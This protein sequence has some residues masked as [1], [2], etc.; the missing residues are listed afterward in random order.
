MTAT[1]SPFLA[2]LAL[3][4]LAAPALAQTPKATDPAIERASH[5]RMVKLLRDIAERSVVD[6]KYHG[7]KQAQDLFDELAKL[8]GKAPWKLRLDA[9]LA[10][11]RLGATR[12]GIRI[13]EQAHEALGSG[14]IEGDLD[15]KN[16][17]RFYLGMAW[18]RLAESDN[19][20]ARPT[21]ESCILPLQGGALHVAKEGSTN[22]IP[23][24]REV[25]ENTPA[26]DF[27]HLGARWL[28]NLAHMTLGT[29]PAG[30]EPKYLIPPEALASKIDFPRFPNVAQKVGLEQFGMLGGVIVDDFDG[31]DDL[32]IVRSLWS[33]DGQIRFWRNDGDGT[34]TDRTA[35]S[36]LT[37]IT[38]GINIFQVDHDNDGDLDIFVVRGA[39]LYD[40]GRHPN[41]LL[42]NLGNGTF[43]DVTFAAGLGEVHYPSS[44]CDWADIDNDGDLDLY[45]GNETSP[46]IRA[47]NQLFRNDGDGTFY[48]IAERAGV[49]NLGYTKGVS[50]GDYD[51]D[52]KVD[53]YV[54]NL[55][56]ENRL[57]HNLGGNRFE[58]V[59]AKANVREPIESFGTWFWDHDNDGNL[60]L[61]VAA[62]STGVGD[63]GAWYLGQPRPNPDVMR[64]Y[65]GDG[66]GGFTNVAPQLGLDYPALP[67]GANFGDLDND[68]W[69]D[70]YLGT[71][72][73][74]YYNLMPN[75]MW[76]NQEGKRFVDIST[77]GGFGHLQKGHGISFADLDS[78]GDLDVYSVQGGAYPGDAAHS[79]LFENPGFGNHW[80]GV[81]L[82]GTDSNR[83]AVGAR[84]RAVFEDGGKERT[85]WREV[86]SG[87]SFGANPLRQML[88]L[89]KATRVKTLEITWPRS[90]KKQTLQDLAVDR[91]V[92]IVEGTDGCTEV[93]L[94]RVVLGGK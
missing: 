46:K 13:L 20:C 22:A 32:D 76:K 88:G 7:R 80:L 52:G 36:G 21:P 51:G 41:S 45:V 89:G 62:Y 58:D 53:L 3:L 55:H 71:G 68:G 49:E 74:Y 12:D 10:H 69:L 4:A 78:D 15:A 44:T 33:A 82:V 54:S 16:A 56:N 75:L 91:L 43:V 28:L 73:P 66:R 35:E 6:H 24:F 23:F 86:G 9:A 50:F 92:R 1:R 84:L 67:M 42:K 90:G 8:E 31:D 60:D 59:A 39:W 85:I 2:P 65:R 40:G 11:L 48:D 18:L 64:L 34:F 26:G 27:W 94:P 25:I 79:A 63:V 61:F 17:I 30:V 38:S 83:S 72:D 87:G 57:Y 93:S 70:F 5:E 47:R 29:H 77:A 81:Q 37:G 19:C 14:A